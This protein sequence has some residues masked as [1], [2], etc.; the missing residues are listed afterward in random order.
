MILICILLSVCCLPIHA[1]TLSKIEY[2]FNRIT[3]EDSI[4][5]VAHY[6]I[7]I[8][9]ILQKKHSVGHVTRKI[10]QL[11]YNNSNY[12]FAYNYEAM[13]EY[14]NSIKKTLSDNYVLND[15]IQRSRYLLQYSK[16]KDENG[17]WV[18]TGGAYKGEWD[19][20]NCYAYAINR[21]ES[22]PFYATTFKYQPGDMA[23]DDYDPS[24]IN[25]FEDCET[26]FDL[27]ELVEKDLLA[28]GYSNITISS[29]LPT[30]NSS[31][32]LICVRM[33]EEDY[34]FMH[35]SQ[36]DGAWYHKPSATA[37]LKYNS[38]PQNSLIWNNERSRNGV[39]YSPYLTYNSPI[40]F[41]R[42]NKNLVNISSS[43]SNL[44]YYLDI[45]TGKDSIL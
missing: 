5:F 33:G 13:Q 16:V 37:V 39:E 20:Y 34:H 25:V 32:E 7:T 36:A 6:N 24:A 38:V 43:T 8:P 44:T 45:A 27:A 23:D 12:V 41:I 19:T 15:G 1:K 22:L 3:E 40:L 2:D 11:V 42:Y 17:N 18:N 4:E 28:M 35:Y 31:Q 9:T 14:A 29:S 30:V 26:I 10:I 21:K